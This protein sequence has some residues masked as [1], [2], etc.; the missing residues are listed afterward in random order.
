MKSIILIFLTLIFTAC[1]STKKSTNIS[2]HKVD[3][4]SI[5]T[6]AAVQFEHI[7]DTTTTESGRVVITEIEFLQSDTSNIIERLS[8]NNG[9]LDIVDVRGKSIKSIKQTAIGH[10]EERK[11]KSKEKHD[12]N[13]HKQVALLQKENVQQ[14]KRV[15]PTPDPFRWRYIFYLSIVIFLILLYFKR[16]PIINQIKKILCGL[17]KR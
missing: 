4:F 14:T 6:T 11:G 7:V 16:M 8:I 1:A 17:I 2:E 9:S 15:S 13:E 10:E 12:G 3:S 5:A